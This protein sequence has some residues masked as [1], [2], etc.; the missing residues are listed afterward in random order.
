M[1]LSIF[2]ELMASNIIRLDLLWNYHHLYITHLS[3]ALPVLL[4]IFNITLSQLTLCYN[5]MLLSRY[6]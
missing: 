1:L 3:I 2:L 6:N 5:Q 4:L